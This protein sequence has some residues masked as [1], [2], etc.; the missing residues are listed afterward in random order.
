[1]LDARSAVPNAVRYE[2]LSPAASNPSLSANSSAS[3]DDDCISPPQSRMRRSGHT[4]W[5]SA[6]RTALTTN[7]IAK[8]RL[9]ATEEALGF[10]TTMA[11]EGR[12]TYSA[13]VY[14]VGVVNGVWGVYRSDD[15]GASWTRFND[16]L[17]GW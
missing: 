5:K 14:A 13:A 9:A 2:R 17:R 4:N 3:V 8:R 10:S 1:M 16:D 12:C 15:G 7:P 6:K 11:R